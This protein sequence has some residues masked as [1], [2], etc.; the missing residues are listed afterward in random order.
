MKRVICAGMLVA[1]LQSCR[2]ADAIQ[3]H[4]T[5]ASIEKKELHR[6]GSDN[7]VIQYWREEDHRILYEER[8]PL[9]D[10]GFAVGTRAMIL[11]KK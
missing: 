9:N 2:I 1:L 7:L 3:V 6:L 10:T 11:V 8:L 4:T 5:F